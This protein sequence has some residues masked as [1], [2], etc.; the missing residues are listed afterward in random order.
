MDNNATVTKSGFDTAFQ[1]P[2]G[3]TLGTELSLIVEP[4]GYK[5]TQRFGYAYS[6]KEFD[7]LDPDFRVNLPDDVDAGSKNDDYVLWYNFDQYV[8]TEQDDPSQGVG[9]F[10]R[11]GYS[12]GKANVLDEFYSFGIGGKGI[13][14]DRDE[15]T[16]GLGYYYAG[17]SGGFPKSANLSH[18]EGIEVYYA[19]Q[20]TKSIQVTQALQW[21]KDPGAGGT[22]SIGNAVVLGLR[23]QM[24]F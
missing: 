13:V 17:V 23:I 20:M 9:L 24:D 19:A 22:D 10:G 21:I 16:F 18:E 4:C 14:E 2:Q 8:F 7:R 5:G 12:N 6:N 1:S 11:Y 15:D 3:T